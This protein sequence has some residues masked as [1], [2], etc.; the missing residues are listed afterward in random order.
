MISVSINWLKWFQ[1]LVTQMKMRFN[2]VLKVNTLFWFVWSSWSV[3]GL[4]YNHGLLKMTFTI[5]FSC[6]L[7]QQFKLFPNCHL[8]SSFLLIRVSLSTVGIFWLLFIWTDLYL[9]ADRLN[10]SL[11]NPS[12]VTHKEWTYYTYLKT[13]HSYCFYLKVGLT[14]KFNLITILK[15]IT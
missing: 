1:C 11:D 5:T 4:N 14:S 3:L 13:P 15:L 6:K 12:D 8:F 9:I 10:H 2:H 7:L